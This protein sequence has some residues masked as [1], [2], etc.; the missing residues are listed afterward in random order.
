MRNPNRIP[1][2][3]AKL[4]YIWKMYPDLRFGQL[5]DNLIHPNY[6]RLQEDCITESIFDNEIQNPKM[7]IEG[8][9]NE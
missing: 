4:E 3:L 6:L 2:M 7:Y 5:V 8:K 1:V 9:S